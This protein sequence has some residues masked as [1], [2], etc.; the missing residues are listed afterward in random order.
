MTELR[1]TLFSMVLAVVLCLIFPGYLFSQPVGGE[2]AYPDLEVADVFS[3]HMVF[4]RDLPIPVWGWTQ[5]GQT[6]TVAF[7]G[8]KASAVAAS[9]GRWQAVL[10]PLPAG[11][12]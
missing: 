5:P 2:K 11:G 9:E 12:P 6:V 8:K 4:Q 3:D 7:A 10:A 1:W